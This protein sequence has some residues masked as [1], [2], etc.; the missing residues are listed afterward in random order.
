MGSCLS[1]FS[2]FFFSF[3]FFYS[4]FN[5]SERLLLLRTYNFSPSWFR[6]KFFFFFGLCQ[7][8]GRQQF[9]FLWFFS[10]IFV[11]LMRPVEK[12][13]DGRLEEKKNPNATIFIF[14]RWV[15][16]SKNIFFVF[17]FCKFKY[18]SSDLKLIYF[19]YKPG[20]NCFRL[21]QTGRFFY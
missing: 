8:S 14:I 10:Y 12:E 5:W 15:S 9:V 3:F 21:W 20:V 11:F 4:F 18:T 16:T 1:F 6:I 7:I 19:W 2:F 17:F 13:F